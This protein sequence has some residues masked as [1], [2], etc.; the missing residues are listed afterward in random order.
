[1][2]RVPRGQKRHFGKN[3]LEEGTFRDL[4]AWQ[5]AN[6]EN[7]GCH[8]RYLTPHMAITVAMQLATS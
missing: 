2:A 6:T 8:P 4:R 3:F 5:Q 7:H 1:V